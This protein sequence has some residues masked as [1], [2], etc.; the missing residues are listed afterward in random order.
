MSLIAGL[1]FMFIFAACGDGAGDDDGGNHSHLY[2]TDWTYNPIQHWRSC[3]C[4]DKTMAANHSGNPCAACGF[5]RSSNSGG[6]LGAE[7]NLKGQIWT[8]TVDLDWDWYYETGKMKTVWER[9]TGNGVIVSA[10]YTIHDDI[11]N[12]DIS[13]E[14]GGSGAISNGQM[15]FT[16]KTPSELLSVGEC[17]PGLEEEYTNFEITPANARGAIFSELIAIIDGKT[18]MLFRYDYEFGYGENTSFLESVTYMYVDRD[19][20]LK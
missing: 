1:I 2:S 15:D 4:G 6:F 19:A 3:S 13:R 20:T 16:I 5:S 12:K 9:F 7:L 8:V 18:H 14:I 17:L 11:L 10:G